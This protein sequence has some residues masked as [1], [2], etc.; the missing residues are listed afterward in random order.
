MKLY[1]RLL[2]CCVAGASIISCSATNRL[3]MTVTEP[4]I[5]SL[6]NNVKRVGIINRSVPQEGKAGLAKIDA[7]LSAEGLKLDKEGAEAAIEGLAERLRVSNRFEAV[8]VLDSLPEIAKGALRMTWSRPTRWTT[9]MVS[10]RPVN[11][12]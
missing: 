7:I 8:V 3:S 2:I 6:P 11:G 4:A 1:F 12:R 10:T 5:V 9:L